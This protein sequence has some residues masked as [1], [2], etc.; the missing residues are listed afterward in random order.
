MTEER[1]M[2]LEKNYLIEKKELDRQIIEL[3]DE[4]D[5]LFVGLDV[6]RYNRFKTIVQEAKVTS[7]NAENRKTLKELLYFLM[8]NRKKG[9]KYYDVKEISLKAFK[10][11]AYII[12]T[13][14]I[15]DKKESVLHMSKEVLKT[16]QDIKYNINALTFNYRFS[17]IFLEEAT[18][19]YNSTNKNKEDNI[20]LPKI[21][22]ESKSSRLNY[23]DKNMIIQKLKDN[24]KQIKQNEKQH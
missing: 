6:A 8:I 14:L 20:F 21:F 15:D 11:C 18:K 16:L 4:R 17:L 13:L 23:L 22:L 19:Y 3:Q 2:Q 10:I 7:N 5:I 1:L 9:D 12:D 24:Y